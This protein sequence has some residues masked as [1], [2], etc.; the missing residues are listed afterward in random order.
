MGFFGVGDI[1]VEGE[2][3]DGLLI[4]FFVDENSIKLL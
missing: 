4:F 2:R 1:E 3:N